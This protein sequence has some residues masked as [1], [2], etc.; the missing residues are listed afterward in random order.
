MSFHLP[1][2][3]DA[4]EA[5]RAALRALIGAL[6]AAL[7]AAWIT[8]APGLLRTAGA[9]EADH[10]YPWLERQQTSPSRPAGR[11]TRLGTRS[12]RRSRV[13]G[14][15]SPVA[16]RG[17][18]GIRDANG[19]RARASKDPRCL[20]WSIRA[21][22]AQVTAAC[23]PMAILSTERPGA[24][25]PTGAL[26]LHADCQAADFKP[27]NSACAYRALKDWRHGLSLDG[28]HIG[29]IHIS[30]PGIR[31]EGR[32]YHYRKGFPRTLSAERREHRL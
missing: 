19:N 12:E 5:N 15:A 1:Q 9:Q 18:L 3:F 25:V 16:T 23:G 4:R 11:V 22:L 26:S 31:N 20:P 7:I 24:R 30:A 29:H 17:R 6:V 13:S 32:F 21:A 28:P 2:H 8:L 10:R 27:K 14:G